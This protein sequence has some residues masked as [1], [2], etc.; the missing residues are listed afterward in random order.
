[1]PRQP[2]QARG[3]AAV[4]SG[5]KKRAKEWGVDYVRRKGLPVQDGGALNKFGDVEQC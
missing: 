3:E 5:G 4:G 2:W 1:M